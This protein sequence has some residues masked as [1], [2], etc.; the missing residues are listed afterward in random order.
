MP[1]DSEA[2]QYEAF[3]QLLEK[4]GLSHIEGPSANSVLV[5][6]LSAL[7]ARRASRI[8]GAATARTERVAV[9]AAGL[10]NPHNVAAV[11]RTAEAFGVQN[12][13]AYIEAADI[14]NGGDEKPGNADQKIGSGRG[15][16]D[17]IEKRGWDVLRDTGTQSIGYEPW[18]SAQKTLKPEEILKKWL[19]IASVQKVAKGA[20]KWLTW[21]PSTSPDACVASL[22]SSGY[23]IWVSSLA[24]DSVSIYDLG[25]RLVAEPSTRV[26]I[27][28]G[29]EREGVHPT[30]REAANGTFTVP[31]QGMV[32][33]CN[34]SVAAAVSISA[35]CAPSRTRDPENF[36]VTKPQAA[37]LVTWW[38]CGPSQGQSESEFSKGVGS[39]LTG[40]SRQVHA[41]TD[42]P[43]RSLRSKSSVTT[44]GFDFERQVLELGPFWRPDASQK[45]QLGDSL[46]WRFALD[47]GRGKYL[48]EYAMRRR[49]GS[50]VENSY[51]WR[52][53]TL[54]KGVCGAHALLMCASLGGTH[55]STYLEKLDVISTSV[56]GA[57]ESIQASDDP[58]T[59][60]HQIEL[61]IASSVL[62]AVANVTKKA[63][64]EVRLVL[65]SAGFESFGAV[66]CRISQVS[67]TEI[68]AWT[69]CSS[70]ADIVAVSEAEKPA[71]DATWSMFLGGFGLDYHRPP[72]LS[73]MPSDLPRRAEDGDD[74][75]RVLECVLRAGSMAYA[76]A[77]VHLRVLSRARAVARRKRKWGVCGHTLDA[78]VAQSFDRG[79][80]GPREDDAEVGDIP[81]DEERRRARAA[82]TAA[83]RT[84]GWL[85]QMVLG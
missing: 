71:D 70:F 64:A 69:G 50:I 57:C 18:V 22:K 61:A 35:I 5:R 25:E 6:R 76:V 85:R 34:V 15:M 1:V 40:T 79:W 41:P 74:N 55:P 33:S 54:S 51:T 84:L 14:E 67:D 32:E 21:H 20:D 52:C 23:E 47:P 11:S 27:V 24:P 12:V 2:P 58:A 53:T 65:E 17:S 59:C 66:L 49:A 72:I 68:L 10:E 56:N 13:F 83:M 77:E 16:E 46:R 3:S 9:V 36:V 30:I 81:G 75:V 80:R 38:L 63:S 4:L 19:N 28:F 73:S 60:L 82:V 37:E 43:K 26:A 29:N 62:T 44:L 31:M 7:S 45:E 39:T 48:D 8:V 78:A 42:A